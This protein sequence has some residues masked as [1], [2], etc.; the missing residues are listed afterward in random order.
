MWL[1]L[2]PFA[3]GVASLGVV[4][5]PARLEALG[6]NPEAMLRAAVADVPL[7]ARFLQN[8]DW[9]TGMPV[10]SLRNYSANVSTLY[11]DHFALL[12]N[13]SEFLD[14][15]FS[16][17]VTVAVVSS[18]LAAA[19]L[20][21]QL[22]GEAVDWQRDYAKRLA[23]GVEAFKTYVLGWYDGSFQDVIY[24][25]EDNPEIRAMIC[26]ILAGYAWDT[27]NPYVEKPQRRLAALAEVVRG[28]R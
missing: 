14:P 6:D 10:R 4:G 20:D 3:D 28:Q 11:G 27:D 9:N 5:E 12:G 17:G 19:A 2:I 26:A 8:A 24:A 23:V 18:Q 15:V 22:R 16:S 13:A 7:L 1:W 21:R 25:S